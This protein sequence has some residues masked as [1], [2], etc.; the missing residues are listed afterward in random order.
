MRDEPGAVAPDWGEPLQCL[1]TGAGGFVGSAVGRWLASCGV[2]VHGTTRTPGSRPDPGVQTHFVDLAD[3]EATAR[4]FAD[5]SPRVVVH[6]AA[7]SSASHN[8]TVESDSYRDTVET[9]SVVAHLCREFNVHSLVHMGSALE[10]GPSDRPIS[11]D[12]PLAPV[13]QRGRSKAEASQ[14]ALAAAGAGLRVTVLRAFRVFGPRERED[15]FIPRAIRAATEGDPLPVPLVPVYRDFVHVDDVAH[16]CALAMQRTS[17]EPLVVNIATGIQT[18][19]LDVVAVLEDLTGR[20]LPLSPEP[21]PARTV[22]AEPYL[23]DTTRARQ[24]LGWNA[25]W[26]LRSGLADLL[27]RSYSRW[28]PP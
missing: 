27:E 5:V 3:P 19:V 7:G 13:T 20:P 15:R 18:S 4:V 16:A 21:F 23:A 22:D 24:M 8:V 28:R 14:I 12:A 25:H 11:E 6:C 2:K 26:T 10:Y 1:I 9:T 17:E